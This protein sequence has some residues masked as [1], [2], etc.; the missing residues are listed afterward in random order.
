MSRS[1]K[2]KLLLIGSLTLALP[3]ALLG[4]R[5][6]TGSRASA[7][8]ARVL[9]G[10]RFPVQALAFSPDGD[11]LTLAACYFLS[12]DERGVPV[13][14]AVWEVGSGKRLEHPAT[15]PRSPEFPEREADPLREC[16]G[17]GLTSSR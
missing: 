16:T 3:A 9:E 4:L 1:K 17:Q 10:H 2:W 15:D 14:V 11:T 5:H 13:E 12:P 7:D 8:P 6:R